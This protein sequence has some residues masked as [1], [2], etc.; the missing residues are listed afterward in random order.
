MLSFAEGIS[1]SKVTDNA[2][3][4]KYP[5]TWNQEQCEHQE[6]IDRM[7][8]VSSKL[9][10]HSNEINKE[11]N[12]L[13]VNDILNKAAGMKDAN[14]KDGG[15]SVKLKSNEQEVQQNIRLL[16]SVQV[17]VNSLVYSTVHFTNEMIDMANL[18]F[19]STELF[20]SSSNISFVLCITDY[21]VYI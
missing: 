12:I 9:L 10:N 3:N 6:F 4:S 11:M 8:N 16:L 13:W 21:K 14:V 15:A 5:S 17:A 7:Q 18:I 20:F 2:A 1:K 19:T